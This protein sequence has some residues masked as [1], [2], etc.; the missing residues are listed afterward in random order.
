MSGEAEPIISRRLAAI[1]VIVSA[2]S[3]ISAVALYAFAPELRGEQSSEANVLSKSAVGFAGIR[4]IMDNLHF[5][6][7]LGREAADMSETSLEVLTPEPYSSPGDVA[8]AARPGPSLIILPKWIA[9]ADPQH[10]GWVI[11]RMRNGPFCL[12]TTAR[13]R[14]SRLVNAL[15]AVRVPGVASIVV[16][17]I[18][19]D[20]SR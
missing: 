6:T 11:V 2:L 9:M 1:L 19:A 14:N 7:R 16:A 17:V 18:R 10:S 12:R 15:P 8:G 5:G 3:L 4:A 20:P 13:S